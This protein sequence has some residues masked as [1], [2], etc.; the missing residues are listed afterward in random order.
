MIE[1]GAWLDQRL[2][3]VPTTL[4]SRV[5]DAADVQRATCRV[6]HDGVRCTLH[7]EHLQEA[8]R[9]LLSSVM[10]DGEGADPIDLLAADALMT[11]ACEAQAEFDPRKL[12]N[13]S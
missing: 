6:N 13:I 8:G 11:F 4:R 12:A 9:A 3:G 1:L 2:H 7:V 5:K 10:D